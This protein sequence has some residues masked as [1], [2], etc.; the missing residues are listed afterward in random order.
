MSDAI[1]NIAGS[2]KNAPW[3]VIPA[4]AVATSLCLFAWSF[5][6]VG[7]EPESIEN[8]TEAVTPGYGD[9]ISLYM[10]KTAAAEETLALASTYSEEDLLRA[11]GHEAEAAGSGGALNEE[12]L[13]K[14]EELEKENEGY[15]EQIRSGLN[16]NSEYFRGESYQNYD[17]PEMPDMSLVAIATDIAESKIESTI[18]KAIGIPGWVNTLNTIKKGYEAATAKPDYLMYSMAQTITEDADVINSF[19]EEKEIDG[20]TVRGAVSA[21]FRLCQSYTTYSNMNLAI[22][23]V[24]LPTP[25]PGAVQDPYYSYAAN[26]GKI[27][28]YKKMAGVS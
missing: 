18:K 7:A 16:E 10:E 27:E 21:Y 23:G 15:L 20:E 12:L 22:N 28:V 25:S 19:M 6:R 8:Y 2:V 4:V 9:K 13:K 1:K 26:L 3:R 17:A 11:F 14:I 24:T 5:T